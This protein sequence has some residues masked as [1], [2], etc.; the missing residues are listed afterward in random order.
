MVEEFSHGN[1]SLPSLSDQ[2]SELGLLVWNCPKDW[3]AMETS[4]WDFEVERIIQVDPVVDTR[5]GPR[6][7]G[8]FVEI[9]D[10]VA[11]TEIIKQLGWPFLLET[12]LCFFRIAVRNSILCF[13]IMHPL[14][15]VPVVK[16]LRRDLDF[17]LLQYT[18]NTL[19]EAQ[20]PPFVELRQEPLFQGS[21]LLSPSRPRALYL[22]GLLRMTKW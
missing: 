16:S 15:L 8:A 12:D 3:D 22:R 20:L 1:R 2:V 21:K 4:R 6:W 13:Q 17:L 7:N 14:S 10:L 18:P 9:D 11:V 5:L 19:L